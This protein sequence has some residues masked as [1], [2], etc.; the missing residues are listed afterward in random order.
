MVKDE[1]MLSGFGG[2]ISFLIIVPSYNV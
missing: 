1:K 2:K